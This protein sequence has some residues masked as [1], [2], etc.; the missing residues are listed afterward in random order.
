MNAGD[1]KFIAINGRLSI[2]LE[3]IQITCDR[4]SGPGGQN[5]NKV[6]TRASLRFDVV[7]SPSLTPMQKQRI[8][9]DLATRIN[10]EGVLRVVS[11]RFRTQGANRDAAIERFR[12]L[13]QEALQPREVR[14][15][16][17]TPQSVIR[18]RRQDKAHRAK[19]K[20]NRRK[21]RLDDQQ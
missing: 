17:R 5:V 1:D 7:N 2:P 6:A 16:T 10:R 8:S 11:S 9:A 20:E 15:P 4:S 19:V 3:E 12:E 21:P 14:I 13:L 18:K